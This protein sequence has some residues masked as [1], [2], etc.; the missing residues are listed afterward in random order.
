MLLVDFQI[1]EEIRQG[2]LKI[3]PFKE[4]NV[5]PSSLDVRLGG[6]FA[7]VKPST[8][9]IDP[10]DTLS[11]RTTQEDLNKYVL[12]PG[13]LVLGVLEEHISLP[14]NISASL[15]G[16]SSLGRLGLDNSSFAGWIDAGFSGVLVI[17]LANHSKNPILL[18]KGMKIGQLTFYKHCNAEIPYGLKPSSKY[19][20]QKG[21]QGSKGVDK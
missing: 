4:E 2:N 12:L 14:P 13:E 17:E 19:Q 9:V 1:K 18:T 15:R 11:F 7:T 5:N 21:V 6:S 3:T 8:V 16:K 10:T 20:D